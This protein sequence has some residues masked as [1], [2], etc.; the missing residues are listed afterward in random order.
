MAPV[1]A[2]QL[3]SS[4]R[5]TQIG[6]PQ[7]RLSVNLVLKSGR[8]A[9]REESSGPWH[10]VV[11]LVPHLPPGHGGCLLSS[12]GAA[13]GVHWPKQMMHHRSHGH[14]GGLLFMSPA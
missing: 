4:T 11:H 8:T 7:P 14:A 1:V 6:W 2:H 9:W 3:H 13:L 5:L 12:W 10:G